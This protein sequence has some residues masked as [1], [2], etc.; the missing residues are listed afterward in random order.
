VVYEIDNAA[1]ERVG[2]SSKIVIADRVFYV[3]YFISGQ[4]RFFSGDQQGTIQ[5]EIS[6]AEFELW[7]NIL[8]DN[9][10]DVNEITKKLSLGKKY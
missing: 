3:K 9:Q 10:A 4:D 7:L 2:C 8:S 1:G 6:K 5:K